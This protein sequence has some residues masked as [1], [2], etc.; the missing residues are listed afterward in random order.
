MRAQLVRQLVTGLVV[1]VGLTVILGFGYPLVVTGLAQAG[2]SHQANGSLIHRNGKLVGSSLLAQAFTDKAGNP[3]P[4]YFQPRPSA[5]DYDGEASAASN[6]GPSNPLLVGFVAGVNT[7]GLNGQPSATNPF[8]TAADPACVPLDPKGSPVTEPAEGQRYERTATGAY[9]CDPD[10]VPER[11]LA[12]RRFN[13]L[14][15]NAVVPVDAVTASG[16][17]LDPDISVANAMDQA[18][19]VARA[20]HLPVSEVDSMVHEHTSGSQLG[21]FGESSVDVLQLNLALDHLAPASRTGGGQ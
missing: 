11:A 19:R 9:V 1:L 21:F 10:T 3:L 8:A 7:V 17:G 2:F 16:S 15:A 6:L 18:P 13:G 20:R 12:Y 5:A 14:A 4:R